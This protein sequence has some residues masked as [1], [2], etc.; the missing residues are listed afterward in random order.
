MFN[1]DTNNVE[2]CCDEN[3][4][5]KIWAWIE[6][7]STIYSPTFFYVAPRILLNLKLNKIVAN[8]NWDFFKKKSENL[9][10]L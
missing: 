3:Y 5:R 4:K 1:K 10:K 2:V 8:K 6:Y 9:K 7:F